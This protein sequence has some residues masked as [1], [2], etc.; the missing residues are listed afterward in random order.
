[1]VNAIL[2]ILQMILAAGNICIIGYGF[3]KFLGKPHSTL[4]SKV[5][6]LDTELKELRDRVKEGDR[7]IDVNGDALEAIQRCLVCLLE[8]EINY[9]IS[10]GYG[11]NTGALEEAKKEL[12]SYLVKRR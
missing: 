7:H 9:C 4:E 2:P 10:T 3:Y 8:F 12:N 6:Q 11:G 1:M 5:V